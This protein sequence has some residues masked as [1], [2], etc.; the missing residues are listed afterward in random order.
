MLVRELAAELARSGIRV[1][2]ISPGSIWTRALPIP[3]E[4]VK[5]AGTVIPLGRFGYP[6]EVAHLALFLL[7][8]LWAGYI[9]GSNFAVDGGLQLYSW[10]V[11]PQRNLY[12]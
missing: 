10:A 2:A 4:S 3:D 7:S 5:R 1:N 8:D 9:T 11:D 6:E 12:H